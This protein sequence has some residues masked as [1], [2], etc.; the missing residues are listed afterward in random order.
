MAIAGAKRE[1]VAVKATTEIERKEVLPP[2][3]VVAVD[4]YYEPKHNLLTHIAGSKWNVI[5]YK[6]VKTRDE[7]AEPFNYHRPAPYQQYTKI[8][9]FELKVTTPISFSPD[10]DNA[11]GQVLGVANVFPSIVPNHGDHFIADIGDGRSGFFHIK[12]V[13]QKSHLRDSVYEI[14]YELQDIVNPDLLEKLEEK[15]VKTA[16]YERAYAD[17]GANPILDTEQHGYY[18]RIRLWQQRI[19]NHY[20]DSFFDSE[21]R[22][23]MVPI[24]GYELY[25]PFIVQFI[26]RIWTT[27]D[28]PELLDLKT[29]NWDASHNRYVRTI[30]DVILENDLYMVSKCAKEFAMIPRRIF[31]KGN[32]GLANISMSRIPNI[33]HPIEYLNSGK[34]VYIPH[35]GK[36]QF[37]EIYSKQ[38]TP[39]K[40]HISLQ[41]LP[42]LGFVHPDLVIK[43]MQPDI[44]KQKEIDTYVVS[45]AFYS[46][47]VENMSKVEKMLFNV[48][49][50]DVINASELL[51]ILEDCV[52][53][54]DAERFYYIP[55][56]VALSQS[57]LGELSQ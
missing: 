33:Y 13:T 11:S 54:P 5:Y 10:N 25:D 51:P 7:A 18:K 32:T 21:Y 16:Y 20:F 56:L 55:L 3:K 24:E 37:S 49:N 43:P 12:E 17:Y 26:Q 40:L 6:Q 29:Y 42:G 4:T 34:E 52:E 22:T 31:Q 57:A 1:K 47:D 30:W 41:K 28:I 48:L 38:N 53:W 15:V 44:I 9:N 36:L 50:E 45:E 8:E 35:V 19:A 23:F 39:R 27:D 2:P 46:K 14:E